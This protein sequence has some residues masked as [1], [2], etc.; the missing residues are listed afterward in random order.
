[1][2]KWRRFVNSNSFIVKR[3]SVVL[4]V[5]KENI[6]EICEVFIEEKLV[7]WN[8]GKNYRIFEIDGYSVGDLEG[9][10]D[11]KV[12][13]LGASEGTSECTIVG[14]WEGWI[15]GLIGLLDGKNDGL[16]DGRKEGCI[17]GKVDGVEIGR[18]FGI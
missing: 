16:N 6:I 7:G 14:E 3:S 2:L 9:N 15:E 13:M 12:Y 8:E 11:G 18:F 10:K 1:M 17:K 4:K 5:V